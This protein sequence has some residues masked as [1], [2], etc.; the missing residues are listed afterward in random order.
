VGY[1]YDITT[2]D[3]GPYNNGTHEITVSYEFGFDKP[4]IKSPRFF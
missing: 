1:S 2:S 3:L 4:E